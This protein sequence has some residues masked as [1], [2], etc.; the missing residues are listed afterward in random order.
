MM[1]TIHIDWWFCW[2]R[3]LDENMVRMWNMAQIQL[4]ETFLW[5]HLH[6]LATAYL[7]YTLCGAYYSKS[8]SLEPMKQKWKKKQ[9]K[10]KKFIRQCNCKD[11]LMRCIFERSLKLKLKVVIYFKMRG[12]ISFFSK[13]DKDKSNEDDEPWARKASNK[14]QNLKICFLQINRVV[15]DQT[16]YHNEDVHSWLPYCWHWCWLSDSDWWHGFHLI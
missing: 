13:K 11:V 5:Q 10:G 12:N 4:D 16:T 7:E 15:K 2:T 9:Q 1:I 6:K 8:L 3:R 14:Q